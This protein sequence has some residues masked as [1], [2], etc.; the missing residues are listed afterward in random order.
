ME[1]ATTS[2]SLK[3]AGVSLTVGQ[4]RLLDRVELSI[5]P[6]ALRVLFGGNGAGKTTLLRLIAGLEAPDTGEIQIGNR[7]VSRGGAVLVPPHARGTALVFQEGALWA[8]LSV[9]RHLRFGLERRISEA[10]ERDHRVAEAL[11]FFGLEA[12]RNRYP[13]QLSGGEQQRLNLARALVQPASLFLLDEP[14]VHLDLA[15]QRPLTRAL[16]ET[17]RARGATVLWVTHSLAEI[18]LLGAPVSVLSGGRIAAD[19]PAEEIEPWLRAQEQ[20]PA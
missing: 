2:A 5:D 19:L 11:G 14:T 9:E 8:H 17:L 13:G 18:E 16:A 4:R 12:D 6:G 20:L 1:S 3:L 7:T 10:A 15:S